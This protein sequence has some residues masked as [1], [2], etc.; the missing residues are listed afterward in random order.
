MSIVIKRSTYYSFISQP[1]PLLCIIHTRWRYA[2]TTTSTTTTTL[3]HWHNN[4]I[5]QQQSNQSAV[6]NCNHVNVSIYNNRKQRQQLR[7]MIR[8][9]LLYSNDRAHRTFASSSSS[10][11]KKKK[12]PFDNTYGVTFT[13]SPDQALE[14]FIKWAQMEQGLNTYIMN[15]SGVLVTAAYCPVWSFDL[16]LRFLVTNTTTGR[17][18]LDW[19]PEIFRSVYGTQSI[20]HI[21]GLSAYAGY[22][23]RRTLMDPLHNTTL[24][25]M[26]DK[27]V[28]FGAWMLRDMKMSS[29]NATIPIV[30]DPWNAPP[31][32]AL[33][34]V[35]EGIESLTEGLAED[36]VV[37]VQAELVTSRRVYMPTYVIK[38]YILGMEYVSFCAL[39]SCFICVYQLTYQLCSML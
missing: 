26:Y 11:T 21:P 19:K 29:T 31:G 34:I 12:S 4:I 28:P 18:R 10:T 25:F 24:V 20:V 30:P 36:E 14:K 9:S 8:S 39:H 37:R 22:T 27:V 2:T 16:N 17:K 23:Y 6:I 3:F 15:P 1:P 35:K 32:R 13:V 33:S 5:K 7:T 38:Y